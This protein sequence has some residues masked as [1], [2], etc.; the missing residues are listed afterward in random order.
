MKFFEYLR[1]KRQKRIEKIQ[2]AIDSH[3]ELKKERLSILKEII[4]NRGK[5]VDD[6]IVYE[7]SQDPDMPKPEPFNWPKGTVRGILTLWIVLIFCIIALWNFI[8]GAGMIP[9]RWFLGLVGAVI[10]SYFYSRYKM[11]Y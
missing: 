11:K 6:D 1:K 2:S 5:K 3:K 8:S 4:K 10:M 9:I 7:L